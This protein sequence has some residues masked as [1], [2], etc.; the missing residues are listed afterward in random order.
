MLG[1]GRAAIAGLLMVGASAL[2]TVGVSHGLGAFAGQTDNN[3]NSFTTA[4]SFSGAGSPAIAF[5]T[6]SPPA[7]VASM[8]APLPI[9]DDCPKNTGAPP[10]AICSTPPMKSSQCRE[11][12]SPGP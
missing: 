4:P 12:N 2:T 10:M 11:S 7:S 8:P 1:R 6:S 5:A 3:G 9:A